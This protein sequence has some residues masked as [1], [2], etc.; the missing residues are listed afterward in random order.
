MASTY[1]FQL[2]DLCEP[3]QLHCCLRVEKDYPTM[4][5]NGNKEQGQTS[6]YMLQ[7]GRV[8]GKLL[9]VFSSMKIPA[10]RFTF[11]RSLERFPYDVLY[12]NDADNGWY[13]TG[14]PGM[15]RSVKEACEAI[16][17]VAA[18]IGATEIYTLGSSMGAFGALLFGAKLRAPSLSFDPET[19][20]DL[21]G[22]RSA[23]NMPRNSPRIHKDLFLDLAASQS[24][25][26]IFAGEMDVVDLHCAHRV[27]GL[28]RVTVVTLTDQA[29]STAAHMHGLYGLERIAT[30]F[31]EGKPLPDLSNRGDLCR[32]P[33]VVRALYESE[34][35]VRRRDFGAAV[36]ILSPVAAD[37]MR[38]GA[39]WYRLGVA[40]L[41]L[42]QVD[43]AI[44]SQRIAVQLCPSYPKARLQLGIGLRRAK[45]L[46]EAIEQLSEASAL[47][48]SF[49]APHY[50]RA[51]ALKELGRTDDAEAALTKAWKLDPANKVVGDAL[52]DALEAGIRSRTEMLR[53]LR[54]SAETVGEGA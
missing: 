44:R 36:S 45:K 1:G 5:G 22:S 18:Q 2:Q 43:D 33:N 25:A 41:H 54:P 53:M 40:Q 47:D 13:Q 26:H 8:T 30:D 31:V 32:Y 50:Q 14:I 23:I 12:V 29:H 10:G 51:L 52:A 9:V 35:A 28:D 20:L 6:Y 11:V 37:S 42:G 39:P 24:Q 4:T 19:I 46:E 16:N 34:A 38:A 27:S 48:P 49:A 3:Y 21:P 17:G 7:R 15:G